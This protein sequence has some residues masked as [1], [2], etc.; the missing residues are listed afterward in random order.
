MIKE[1]LKDIIRAE[2]AEPYREE[3]VKLIRPSIRMRTEP[4][5]EQDIGIGAS[6]ICS[7][8]DLPPHLQWACS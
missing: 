1:A 6:K 3:L 5:R 7:V 4:Q 2:V 8:P